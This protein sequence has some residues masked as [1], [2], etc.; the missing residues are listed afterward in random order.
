MNEDIKILIVDDDP[1]V[2]FV[3]SRIIKSAGYEVLEASTGTEGMAVAKENRPDL[4]LMDVKLPDIEGPDLCKR[5]KAD[6]FFQ[7]TFVVLIS[8]LK[9]SS[10]DQAEGLDVG[11]DGYITRPISN[12]ELKA[13]VNAWIRILSAERERNRL[14][15]ELREALAKVKQLSG[16]LPICMHCKKIRDDE[17]YWNQIEEYLHKHSEA[18]FSHSICQD[19]MDK[20]YPDIDQD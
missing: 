6:P 15:V 19:C 11:A 18:E 1:D 12:Q 5:I 4:I 7:G 9:T 13:R 16:F 20:Y 2:L 14:I 10:R 3:T 17:G 8:G